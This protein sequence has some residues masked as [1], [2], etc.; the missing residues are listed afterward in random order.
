MP[1]L[2][3]SKPTRD[4]IPKVLRSISNLLH[5]R[6][7]TPLNQPSIKL[8][9][10]LRRLER[11]LQRIQTPK[12]LLQTDRLNNDLPI[13]WREQANPTP[14]IAR[15]VRPKRKLFERGTCRGFGACAVRHESA[16]QAEHR[17]C[18]PGFTGRAHAFGGAGEEVAV[19][20][21]VAERVA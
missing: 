12:Q 16:L 20:E 17:I 9:T 4:L 10:P 21:T 14:D 13:C 7:N 3:S 5:K 18:D 19:F 6:N 15:R 8:R 1:N 2:P 11:S